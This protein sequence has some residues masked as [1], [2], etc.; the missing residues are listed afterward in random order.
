[1]D[2]PLDEVRQLMSMLSSTQKLLL[3]SE[4]ARDLMI[5]APEKRPHP[6]VRGALADL[7]PAPSEE[8]FEEA[9]RAMSEGFSREEVAR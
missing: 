5:H 1:M 3:I 6:S 4:L 7:G 8:D 9:R 2:S